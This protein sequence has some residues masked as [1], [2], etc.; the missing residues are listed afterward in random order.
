LQVQKI[1][2]SGGD[3]AGDR[4][5]VSH[6]IT[7]TGDKLLIG[8]YTDADNGYN[9]GSAYIF[10]SNS[11]G[12]YQVQ[13]ITSSNPTPADDRFGWAL[14]A[15]QTFNTLAVGARYDDS[16]G[17]IKGAVYIFQSSSVGYQEVQKLTSST[18]VDPASDNFGSALVMTADATKLFIVA[19]NEQGL[20]SNTTGSLYVFESG[21]SGY[22]EKQN[23]PLTNSSPNGIFA[24]QISINQDGSVIAVGN[25]YDN[26]NGAT[27]GVV[28]V[29]KESVGTYNITQQLTQSD[30]VTAGDAFGF[31]VALNDS[32]DTL[33]VTSRFDEENGTQ[34]GAAYIFKDSGAG[35]EETQ[36]LVANDPDGS[37]E[38]DRMG[39][40]C[41]LKGDTLFVSAPYDE[42]A[43]QGS[44]YVFK[45][46]RDY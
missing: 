41:R 18:A 45:Y 39:Y 24:H 38:N 19:T 5:G 33:C 17:V 7:P 25:G 9:G 37:P 13:K 34:A 16:D 11:G 42:V 10:H 31:A 28:Y 26:R 46:T 8:A 23:I 30:S 36:K 27:S 40:D 12:F 4:F 3:L 44:I 20:E 15:D 29:I 35:F 14:S 32:G 21:S 6:A 2:A 43:E 1:T 22:E